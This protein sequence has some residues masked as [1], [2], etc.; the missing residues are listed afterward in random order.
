MVLKISNRDMRLLWLDTNDLIS[1][2]TGKLDI[3]SIIKKLGFVQLDTV[4][5]VSRAHHH[6]LWS[7][8]QN[9][10]EPMLDELLRSRQYIFEHFTH[11]ASILPME[12]YPMWTRRFNRLKEK[13]D[14][15]ECYT[16]EKISNWK[17]IILERIQEEGPLSTKGFDSK[18]KGEKKVWSHPPHKRVLDYLW[19][20]GILS[21][22]HREN[23]NKFYDLSER[24]IPAH[25]RENVSSDS[26]QIDWLCHEA[27]RRLAIGSPREIQA[28]WDAKNINEVK[29]WIN[30]KLDELV[31]VEWETAKGS[32]LNSYAMKDIE[33]RLDKLSS[34]SSRIRIINPFD[35]AVRDRQRL[36]NIFGFDYKLEIFVP[37]PK[38]QWGYYV[39]PLLQGKTFIGRIELKAD[40]K[41]STLNVINLWP[42]EGVK[43]GAEREK[44][45][46]SELSRFTRLANLEKVNW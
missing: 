2:P 15:Y 35:P 3:L 10:R 43:W 17:D 13:I 11:D 19:Y 40:R 33:D 25:Y 12:F 18:I 38:R 6:I 44:K 4:Q 9:Y 28:F 42:E 31:P 45:L 41:A 34:A 14:K 29:S 24:V 27:L 46:E 7:R 1:S 22:S 32:H 36:K 20:V 21:T 39:Y 30:Q 8:N 5:N 26:E 23:F 37:A 16:P